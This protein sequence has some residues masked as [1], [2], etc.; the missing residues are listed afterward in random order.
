M[1]PQYPFW[2]YTQENWNKYSN[3][4]LYM[5][6]YSRTITIA[7]KQKQMSINRWVDKHIVLFSQKG[8]KCWSIHATMWVNFKSIILVKEN[9]AQCV[10]YKIMFKLNIQIREI[11]RDNK[12]VYD[13]PGTMRKQE[14]S[15]LWV[16]WKYSWTRQKWQ[17][18]KIMY[19]LNATWLFTLKWL[20]LLYVTVTS[21]N[22]CL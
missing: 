22:I 14:W 11:Q 10:T 3:K 21:L 19:V 16:W 9:Q 18:H 13:L 1:S 2:V 12:Q 17:L 15:F 5:Y 8:M 6:I 7:K 20:I 4:Y